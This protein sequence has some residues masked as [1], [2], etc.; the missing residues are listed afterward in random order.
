MTKSIRPKSCSNR[1]SIMPSV[2]GS[3]KKFNGTS[4]AEE[5]AS[6]SSAVGSTSS[7]QAFSKVG[8]CN[9]SNWTIF[10]LLSARFTARII[11]IRLMVEDIRIA[12]LLETGY[13][14]FLQVMFE[15]YP[16]PRAKHNFLKPYIFT[17]TNRTTAEVL[18]M[19]LAIETNGLTKK[20]GSLTA[21]KKLN[22]KVERKTIHG[23]LGP[24]G[25]GKTTTIKILVGL[26]KPNEGTV[27]VLGQ[28]KW[29]IN[30]YS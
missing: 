22:L 8:F 23:F 12:L 25:A 11:R 16:S 27:K 13:P 6:N 2:S 10:S 30:T 15:F 26:L 14:R 20:Y 1:R 3:F 5:T 7:N 4:D 21:V 18:L 29:N 24:N 9:S 28:V 17:V 19:E